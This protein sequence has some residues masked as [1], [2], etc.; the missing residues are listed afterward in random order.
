M[1][2]A[3]YSSFCKLERLEFVKVLTEAVVNQDDEHVGIETT[4]ALGSRV[5][6]VHI[7]IRYHHRI[8]HFQNWCTEYTRLIV[9]L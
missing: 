3:A 7:G 5:A 4:N 6:D 9:Y 1:L 8:G 2:K